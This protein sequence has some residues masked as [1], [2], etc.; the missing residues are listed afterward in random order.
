MKA[1]IRD[2]E[3]LR[4]I[5]PLDLVSYL[6][7]AGWKKVSGQDGKYSVWV[8]SLTGDAIEVIVPLTVEFGDFAARI[9]DVLGSLE[10]LEARSQIDI[11][12]DIA[13][14]TFD[15]IRIRPEIPRTQDGTISLES[16]IKLVEN[17]RE[18]MLA[19]A[20]S[21]IEP[22]P[23]YPT[24]KPSQAMDY[25][26]RIRLGQTEFGSYVITVRSPIPPELKIQL[27]QL[28]LL[29]E[30]QPEPEPEPFERQ[31]TQTL[32]C[33]LDALN[34]AASRGIENG[35]LAPFKDAIKLGVSA[36]LCDAIAALQ[37]ETESSNLNMNISW[38]HARPVPETFKTRFSFLPDSVEVIREAARIFKETAPRDNFEL[39]GTVVR[40]TREQDKPGS[41]TFLAPVEGSLKK[42]QAELIGD[43]YSKACNAHRDRL[44]VKCMGN[45]LHEGK[46]YKLSSPHSFEVVEEISE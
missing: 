31:V 8:S 43:D 20:C 6:R 1:R 27:Q 23:Y 46:F 42:I 22:R 3:T 41:V 15:V 30:S 33:S 21:T 11:L 35:D 10:A 39:T 16:G 4:S 5:R 14:T 7:Q 34:I 29:P 18:V 38:G 24:R 32:S 9:S 25:M 26:K 36:N 40:L 44:I 12:N 28:D 45:L 19:A 37:V 2:L 17:A 13:S